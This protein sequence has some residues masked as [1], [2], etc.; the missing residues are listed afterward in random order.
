MVES[1]KL[2][3]LA[4]GWLKWVENSGEKL[5]TPL[6]QSSE[7][8]GWHPVLCRVLPRHSD[9]SL[10]D[11]LPILAARQPKILIRYF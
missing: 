7:V 2:E 3:F 1:T 11:F 10:Q 8:P 6:V 9:T 4:V 5:Y